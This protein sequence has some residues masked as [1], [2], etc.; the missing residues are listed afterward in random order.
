MR[1]GKGERVE[2]PSPSLSPKGER[3][4]KED[5]VRANPGEEKRCDPIG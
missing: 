2:P 3:R 1:D 4:M 5:V